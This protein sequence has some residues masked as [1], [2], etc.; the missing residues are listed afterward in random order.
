MKVQRSTVAAVGLAAYLLAAVASAAYARP[1]HS[2]SDLMTARSFCMGC[3]AM[4]G[5][6]ISADDAFILTLRQ[7]DAAKQLQMVFERATTEGK[8]YALVGL[9]ETDRHWFES[10]FAQMST[11]RFSVVT[12]LTEN[13]NSIL[14]TPGDVV[15]KSIQKGNYRLFVQ[16]ARDGRLS[17]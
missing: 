5:T 1:S 3:E 13:P 7:P 6:I 2:V 4:A 10:D 16:L 12:V 15:L 14:R 17:H 9:R 8:M 11:R